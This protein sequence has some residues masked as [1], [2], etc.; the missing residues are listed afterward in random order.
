V[1]QLA[2]KLVWVTAEAALA[3]GVDRVDWLTV[4]E[5]TPLPD[6]LTARTR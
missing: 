1:F 6:R 5:L 2:V 3:T 4:L